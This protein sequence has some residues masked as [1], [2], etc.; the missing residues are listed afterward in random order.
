M[1]STDAWLV[2][3]KDGVEL[4]MIELRAG[5]P[6]KLSLSID[7]ADAAALK[8]KLDAID[9]P[10]G[11][12]LRMHLPPPSGQGR[13]PYG[14]R[15][16]KYDD[17]LYRHAVK[18]ALEPTFSVKEV[19]GLSDP[20][21]PARIKQL[22]VSRSGEKVGS[23]DFSSN[24][25][26]LTVVTEK[27]E[28]LGIRNNWERIQELGTVKVRYHHQDKDSAPRLITAEAKPGDASY[29]QTV[30]LYLMVERFYQTRYAY[31]LEFS[32]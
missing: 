4:G 28:G 2:V 22:H 11:I 17:R 26:K 7:N 29:A 31:K 19:P 14:S 5:K 13:G 15:I 8:A 6:P 30:V 12:A 21:P 18:D 24:P 16:I 23:I 3:S 27:S 20:L 9:G 32:E 25:P 1:E 10:E